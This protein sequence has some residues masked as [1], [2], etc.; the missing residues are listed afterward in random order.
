MILTPSFVKKFISDLKFTGLNR[1][2]NLCHRTVFRRTKRC[3]KILWDVWN[4][5]NGSE[6]CEFI[7]NMVRI[8]RVK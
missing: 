3:I 1:R 8:F 2:A 5:E 4:V 6:G 7:K